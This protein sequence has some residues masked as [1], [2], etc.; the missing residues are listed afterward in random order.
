MLLPTGFNPDLKS[1]SDLELQRVYYNYTSTISLLD[2]KKVVLG[3]ESE[4]VIR[5]D[6]RKIKQECESRFHISEFRMAPKN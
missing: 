2:E 5:S 6:F 4:S 3:D 1:L